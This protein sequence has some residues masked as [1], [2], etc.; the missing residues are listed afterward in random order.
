MQRIAFE[1]STIDKGPIAFAILCTVAFIPLLTGTGSFVNKSLYHLLL[2]CGMT[3]SA[4]VMSN[5][6]N[7]EDLAIKILISIWAWSIHTILAQFILQISWWIPGSSLMS[8]MQSNFRFALGTSIIVTLSACTFYRVWQNAQMPT[9]WDMVS[10]AC[11]FLCYYCLMAL[12]VFVCIITRTCQHELAAS[13]LLFVPVQITGCVLYA[14]SIIGNDTGGIYA[15][16]D[17]GA[18]FY[19]WMV[20]H[21]PILFQTCRCA[22]FDTDKSCGKQ[23][24]GNF[25]RQMII[26]TMLVLM[27][28]SNLYAYQIEESL[29]ITRHFFFPVSALQSLLWSSRQ[30]RVSVENEKKRY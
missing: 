5:I 28:G 18:G 22:F 4:W 9:E 13:L 2:S 21:S 14:F 25:S 23:V 26:A 1:S 6:N 10:K 15:K 20:I 12:S 7:P 27:F 16:H 17:Q 8:R 24:L 30:S 11:I 3:L 19:Y 29:H